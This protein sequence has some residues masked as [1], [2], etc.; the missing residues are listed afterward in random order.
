MIESLYETD[1]YSDYLIDNHFI[2]AINWFK[3][4]INR[5]YIKISENEKWKKTGFANRTRLVGGNGL[6]HLSV[7]VEKG[8]D[9]KGL[10]KDIKIAY[11]EPWQVRHWRTIVS[12][13]NRSPFFEYYMDGFHPF[14]ERKYTFLFDFNLE[15]TRKILEYLS[16]NKELM[17]IDDEKLKPVDLQAHYLTPKTCTLDPDPVRYHQLFSD[18]VGFYPNLSILDLLFMEGPGA[19]S[20]LL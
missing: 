8:R 12:C 13:Y 9:Q 2:P 18:R 20:F 14:F 19:S 4:S 17:V 16:V 11:H 7:P 5:T 1:D 3:I 10:L 6:V 15:I